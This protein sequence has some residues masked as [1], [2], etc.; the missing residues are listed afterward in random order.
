MKFR[1]CHISLKGS[2]RNE[3]PPWI[4]YEDRENVP[5]GRREAKD[6]VRYWW[7]TGK[8]VFWGHFS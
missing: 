4:V 5:E 6:P 8:M 3:M 7:V 2:V 1:R